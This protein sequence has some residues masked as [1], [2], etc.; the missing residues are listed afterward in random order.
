MGSNYKDKIDVDLSASSGLPDQQKLVIEL[1]DLTSEEQLV[2]PPGRLKAEIE[3]EQY[4]DTENKTRYTFSSVWPLIIA[5]FIGGLIAWVITELSY[6]DYARGYET[7]FQLLIEIGV[8][9]AVV[10]GAIG[11][12]LG[13]VEGISSKVLEKTLKGFAV[14]LGF[15]VLG[16]AAGGVLA[17]VVYS[18]LGGGVHDNILLQ[19]LVRA[20]AWGIVGLFVGIGQGL[21]TGGGKRVLNGLLGGLCGGVLGGLLFDVIGVFTF[22]GALSRAIAIPLIGVFAG[23]GIGLVSEMRKEAWL[24]VLEGFTTGKEY[25]VYDHIT[26]IGSS[27][28]S[29]IVLIKDP[30]VAPNHAEIISENNSYRIRVM[31]DRLTISV[32][33][34][35]ARNHKLKNDDVIAIGNTVLK[36]FEKP[37]KA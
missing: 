37:V 30:S 25:I 6:D 11:A 2:Q 12:S 21:G 35:M 5:G 23:L 22:T 26:T 32:G 1:E 29:E 8:F 34:K 18:I 27:P 20:L 9:T 4:M 7:Y 24:K 14:A 17:Q 28:K 10:G 13:S 36:F 16:G 15:G 19:I 3:T 31:D 33:N